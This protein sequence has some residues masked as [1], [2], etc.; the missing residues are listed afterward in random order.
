MTDAFRRFAQLCSNA[1]G[2]SWTFLIAGLVIIVWAVTGPYFHYSDTWQLVI[3]TGTSVVTFLMVFI[4]QN[5]QNRDARTMQMKLNEL[6][7]AIENARTGLVNLENLDEAD[8]I[9]LQKEFQRIGRRE[10]GAATQAAESG[11]ASAQG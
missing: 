1:V 5:S 11:A 2:S 3:N 8:L 10:N 9:R 4:I 6:L 7:C